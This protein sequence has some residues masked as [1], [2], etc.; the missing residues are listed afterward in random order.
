M[1][2]K[3]KC[4]TK[5][6]DSASDKQQRKESNYSEEAKMKKRILSIALAALLFIGIIPL[7]GAA[8]S[9]L[10]FTDVPTDAWYYNDVKSPSTAGWSTARRRPPTARRTS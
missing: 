9:E 7:A 8:A 4:G 5:R 3:K 6:G 10:A 1:K 2:N